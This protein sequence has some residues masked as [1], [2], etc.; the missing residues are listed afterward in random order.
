MG[1]IISVLLNILSGLITVYTTICF[2]Y[3]LMSWIPGLR[4]TSF[5]RVIASIVEPYMNIFSRWR[6]TH[7]GRVDFSP[8]ISIGLLSLSS[9]ILARITSTGRIYLGGIL[10]TIIYTIWDIF[11]SLIG[12]FALV[13]FIRWIVLL[14]KKGRVD[15]NSGWYQID[16][17]IQNFCYKISGAIIKK[18]VSYTKSLF[19]TWVT[20]AVFD[21]AGS[22]LINLLVHLCYK[23]P[24]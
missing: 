1:S 17:A 13:V 5:G 7:I 4:Y 9:S 19:I 12:I 23:I 2:I 14:V 3:I 10:A 24:F 18:P 11:A 6:F 15:Y 8:I 21:A 20:F 16:S 22:V